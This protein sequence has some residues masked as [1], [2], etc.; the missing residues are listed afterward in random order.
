MMAKYKLPGTYCR[1]ARDK[2]TQL[3]LDWSKYKNN[4]NIETEVDTS[5]T[6]FGNYI[7]TIVAPTTGQD[8]LVEDVT[9]LIFSEFNNLVYDK[10][11]FLSRCFDD[12]KRSVDYEQFKT[13]I[14]NNQGLKAVKLV[15]DRTHC[16]LKEAHEF[17][18]VQKEGYDKFG[19]FSA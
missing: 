15:R 4:I 2:I 7:I 9:R 6:G 12:F 1:A 3:V 13:Y 19:Y 14:V 17:W 10:G 16:G 18:K 5:G 11:I 8:E